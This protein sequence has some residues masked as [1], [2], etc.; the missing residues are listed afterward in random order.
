MGQYTNRLKSNYSK[1]PNALINDSR[2]SME[3]RFVFCYM[4]SKPTGWDFYLEPIADNL[5]KTKDTIRKYLK[6][7]VEYGWLSKFGQSRAEGTSRFSAVEYVLNEFPFA[8][9]N[10]REWSSKLQNT[11]KAVTE[12]SRHGETIA[13]NNKYNTSKKNNE[14]EEGETKI[15]S[16]STFDL[17]N[18]AYMSID[19]CRVWYDKKHQGAKEALCIANK[20]SLNDL[21][22]WQDNFDKFLLS[23]GA[24]AKI[25]RDYAS[26]FANW[27]RKQYLHSP[28]DI[29]MGIPKEY[30]DRGEEGIKEY[31]RLKSFGYFS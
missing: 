21:I 19:E 17:S 10:E 22:K 8:E 3:A 20:I 18:E 23:V 16:T 26:H 31:N 4:A 9:D 29:Q 30:L 6:E 12:N 11:E 24:T 14:E 15:S 2:I 7:L 5:G 13:H 25:G 27:I 28:K 1:V